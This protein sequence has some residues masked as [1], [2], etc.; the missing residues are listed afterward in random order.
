VERV[1]AAIG[2]AIGR[3]WVLIYAN[4]PFWLATFGRRFCIYSAKLNYAQ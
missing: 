3:F 2:V 4:S 1:K